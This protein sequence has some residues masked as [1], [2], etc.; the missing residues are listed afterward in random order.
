MG[1]CPCVSLLVNLG[2][3][4]PVCINASSEFSI[5]YQ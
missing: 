4:N 3:F 5:L 1:R 2:I